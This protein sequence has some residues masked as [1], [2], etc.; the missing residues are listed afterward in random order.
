MIYNEYWGKHGR[1][2]ILH[3]YLREREK[4]KVRESERE[5]FIYIF[6]RLAITMVS[7]DGLEAL[8]PS[9]NCNPLGG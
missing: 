7:I 4:E 9:V 2:N 1:N 5:Q 6:T 8:V 3:S